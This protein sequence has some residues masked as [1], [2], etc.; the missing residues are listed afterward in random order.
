MACSPEINKPLH[1]CA[2][3]KP[4]WVSSPRSCICHWSWWTIDVA[5]CSHKW[6]SCRP[7][8]LQ[9]FQV[10]A[11]KH[12]IHLP[13]PFRTSKVWNCFTTVQAVQALKVQVYP[14]FFPCLRNSLKSAAVAQ[15][16]WHVL[17][18]Y[19]FGE[20]VKIGTP[21]PS[22]IGCDTRYR[23]TSEW[24]TGIHTKEVQRNKNPAANLNHSS[25]YKSSAVV[26]TVHFFFDPSVSEFLLVGNE[27]FSLV[28][29]LKIGGKK[30]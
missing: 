26:S 21:R 30:T 1:V 8:Q 19:E 13:P 7:T 5:H 15:I 17:Q 24:I 27:Y 25:A 9:T 18:I 10:L 22:W 23:F 20:L 29:F 11:V 2:D 14:I 12:H 4:C 28:S 16:L 6:C 3:A